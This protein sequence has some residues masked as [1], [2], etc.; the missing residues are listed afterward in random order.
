MNN[1][2]EL[3]YSAMQSS[4]EG[5]AV[6]VVDSIEFELKRELTTQEHQQV[7]V[8]VDSA[9]TGI[10]AAQKELHDFKMKLSD[11]GCLLVEWK[12]RVEKAEKERDDLLNQEFQ[13]RL[14]NAEHQIYMKDLAIHNIKASRMA[15]FR[16]RLAAEA[17]L[18]AVQLDATRWRA[19][20]SSPAIR[21]LGHA[22]LQDDKPIDGHY[23]HFG[24]E[25]WSHH[26]PYYD[27]KKA[28]ELITRYADNMIAAGFTVEGNADA[29]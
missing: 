12:N 21:I 20:L 10:A 11:A 29:E 27:N 28:G 19:L 14:A 25:I 22:G 9:I 5:Y 17:E 16:K 24:M 26:E 15:Q 18:S 23:C 4:L 13:Q 3:V 6:A 1:I 2:E 7:Y 8:A